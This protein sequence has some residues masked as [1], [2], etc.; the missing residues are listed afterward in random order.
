VKVGF[1]TKLLLLIGLAFFIGVSSIGSYSVLRIR[2]E[3]INSSHHKLTSDLSLAKALLNEKLPGEWSIQGNNL[4]KGNQKINDNF[5]I[6]DEIGSLTGDTVT[7]FLRNQRV[8]TNVKKSDGVRAVGTTVS[9]IVEETTLKQG[10]TYIGQ[11]DV[12]GTINQTAYEPIKDAQ[13]NIIGIWYVGVPN[14]PY[15]QIAL[16]VRKSIITLGIIEL[17]LAVLILWYIIGRSVKSLLIA[18]ESINLVATG[19]LRINHITVK[20]EDEIGQISKSIHMMTDNLRN[21][22][23]QLIENVKQV[24]T[25]SLALST[26]AKEMTDQ[27]RLINAN[28][29]EIAAGMQENSAATQEVTAS[30]ETILMATQQLVQ[31]ANTTA[32]YTNEIRDRAVLVKENALKSSQETQNLYNIKQAH[33]LKAIEDGR[34]VQQIHNMADVI[35]NIAKQT[36]LLALNAAIE[37]ARAGDHGKGFA[38]VADEVRKLAEQSST[39]VVDIHN[40]IRQVEEAFEGISSN[41]KDILKFINTDVNRD[42]DNMMIIGAQYQ[43]DSNLISEYMKEFAVSAGEIAVLIEQVI[44]TMESVAAATEQA[45]ANS[46]EISDMV[47]KTV[48]TGEQISNIVQQHHSLAKSLENIIHKFMVD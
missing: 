37:A 25:M 40:V 23:K 1:R 18:K 34:V 33:I 41:A 43:E 2:T 11:A 5:A 29:L 35:S 45:A 32:G 12:V 10:K 30:S 28:T 47:S 24:N 3:V 9:S 36:N 19:D 20:S 14:T 16:S 31:K 21:V 39:T 4:Y 38:V 27:T 44:Q 6:V 15:D 17:L 8:A 42:Y 22:V 26:A 48:N 13:G 46:A 7:I